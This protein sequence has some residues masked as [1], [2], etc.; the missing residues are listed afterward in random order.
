MNYSVLAEAE[1]LSLV[2]IELLT[3]RTHQIRAQFSSRNLPI[4]GDRKYSLLDDGCDIA[5]W[6]YSLRFAHPGSGET[7]SFSQSPPETY[8]W[9]LF[10][11]KFPR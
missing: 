6:S 1:G 8:P 3:G 11:G 5:L 4:V 9:R 10:S 2:R 7:V